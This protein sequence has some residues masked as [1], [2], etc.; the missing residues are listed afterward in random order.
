[1]SAAAID[2]LEVAQELRAAGF[3]QGTQ[4][5]AVAKIV[6]RARELAFS[7][8]ATKADLATEVSRLEIKIESV[9]SDIV[10]WL[11]GTIGFQMLIMLSAVI[12][13]ARLAH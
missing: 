4:A 10:R 7:A 2:T 6:R 13:L 12:A 3:D 8:L 5:E 1:M 11:F 9:K